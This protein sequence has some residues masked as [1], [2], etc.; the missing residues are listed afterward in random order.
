MNCLHHFNR[1]I[2]HDLILKLSFFQTV[3][4][5]KS[6]IFGPQEMNRVEGT[7]ASIKCYYPPTSVNKHTRKYWCRQENNGICTTLISSQNYISKDYK[8]RAKLTDF[9]ENN[10]FVV[11]IFNL[12]KDDSGLYKCGLGVNSRGLSFDVSLQVSQGKDL[13]SLSLCWEVSSMI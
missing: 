13:G 6:P 9:S 3:A 7:S 4:S 1:F 10:T 2:S 12:T 5:M 8:D 11:N